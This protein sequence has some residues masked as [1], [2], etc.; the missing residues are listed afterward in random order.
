MWAKCPRQWYLGYV[1]NLREYQ[2]SI[3]TL[4]GTAMHETIQFYLKIM[5]EESLKKADSYD[6]NE[7]LEYRLR[8][9][10]KRALEQGN[11]K[12][13]TTP[14]QLLE[15]YKDGVAILEQFKKKRG[16]FFNKRGFKLVGIEEPLRLQMSDASEVEFTGFLDIVLKDTRDNT[17]KIIDIKTS[18]RGWRDREKK[19]FTK[20]MQLLLYKQYYAKKHKIPVESVEVE[21]MIL[22]RKIQEN[23][24][25]PQRRLQSFSP[26]AGSVSI[27]KVNKLVDK[28]L[29]VG[30]NKDGTFKAE[31]GKFAATPGGACT[32]CQFAKMSMCP[33]G[34]VELQSK[35]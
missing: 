7:L 11:G 25:W 28:F 16:M 6:L 24:E 5:Y 26:A 9:N 30:F 4:F 10:Y 18:T 32:W 8:V 27:N 19:D 33:I 1:K 14:D 2:D 13:F 22:K 31:E 20:T 17:I 23:S 34:Y 12:E 29:D 3:H 35:R 15:F 21:Y